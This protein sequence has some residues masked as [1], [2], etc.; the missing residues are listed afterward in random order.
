YARSGEA[1]RA[2]EVVQKVVIPSGDREAIQTGREILLEIDLK[3]AETM[4]NDGD[5]DGGLSILKT[6]DWKSSNEALKKQVREEVAR[7]EGVQEGNRQIAVY[8]Q[9][10]DLANAGEY[11]KAAAI[12]EPLVKDAKSPRVEQNAKN[13]LKRIQEILAAERRR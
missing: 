9:A 7:I 13:L 11:R 8:N 1:A 5:V 6:V 12:L 3:T 10:V 4:I 2:R